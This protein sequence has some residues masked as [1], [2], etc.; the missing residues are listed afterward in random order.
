MRRECV[1]VLDAALSLFLQAVVTNRGCGV[2]RLSDVAGVQLIHGARV[3]SPHAGVTV[4]LQLHTHGNLIE[5]DL[6][7]APA[8]RFPFLECAG[9][10]LHMVAHCDGNGR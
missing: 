2:E 7:D 3:V 4:S 6:K 5:L 8:R 10:L 1:T 9:E